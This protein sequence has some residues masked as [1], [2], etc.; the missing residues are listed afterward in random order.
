MN[1]PDRLHE[2]L[3]EMMRKFKQQLSADG[4]SS[5]SYLHVETL[6]FIKEAEAPDMGAVAGYLRVAAPSATAFV[7]AL[8]DDGLVS[9]KPDPE[10][11]RRVMLA[12]T[13]KGVRALSAAA[14]RREA[15]FDRVFAPLSPADRR[16][17]ARILT[18]ITKR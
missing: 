17:M 18:I 2:L 12:V 10:D 8:A 4:G 13:A 14:K 15:A 7:N 11:R 3:F 9:R 5:M 1:A 6:R 16:E